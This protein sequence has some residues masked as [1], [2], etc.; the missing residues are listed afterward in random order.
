[1]SKHNIYDSGSVSKLLQKNLKKSKKKYDTYEILQGLK[2]AIDSDFSDANIDIDLCKTEL[3][4]ISTKKKNNY[5]KEIKDLII[6]ELYE[7]VDE[8]DIDLLFEINANKNNI[9]VKCKRKIER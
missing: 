2:Y 8:G 9:C 5:M 3:N 7:V 4:I 1:M 6:D